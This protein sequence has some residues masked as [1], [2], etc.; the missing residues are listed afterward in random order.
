MQ[1]ASKI[2]IYEIQKECKE[3]LKSL[4]LS[5]SPSFL[6]LLKIQS[7]YFVELCIRDDCCCTGY[8]TDP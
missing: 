5:I 1:N 7:C 3:N 8:F 6:E 2:G 4:N